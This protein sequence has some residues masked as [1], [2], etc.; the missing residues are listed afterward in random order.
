MQRVVFHYQASRP[1]RQRLSGA[2]AEDTAVE[3]VAPVGRT[4]LVLTPEILERSLARRGRELPTAR[5]RRAP[6]LNRYLSIT[7]DEFANCSS[8][9]F[10]SRNICCHRRLGG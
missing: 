9:Y 10:E 5:R 4:G 1:L 2:A 3:A 6:L 8:C 7:R